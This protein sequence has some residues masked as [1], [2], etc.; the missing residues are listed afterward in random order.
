[1]KKT[2]KT[3]VSVKEENKLNILRGLVQYDTLNEVQ[4]RLSDGYN[5]F[6]YTG[7]DNIVLKVLKPDGTAYIDSLGDR[8]LATSPEDGVITLMLDGQATAAAGVC[9]SVIELYAAGE[10]MTTSRFNYEVFPNLPVGEAIESETEYP[11]LQQ[12]LM[13]L[14]ALQNAIDDAE[15][16]R[17][18]NEKARVEAEK[19][20]ESAEISRKAAETVRQDLE[21]GYVAKASQSAES[22]KQSEIIAKE[23]ERKAL[24]YLEQIVGMIWSGSI[25]EYNALP[26]I[27]DDVWYHILEGEI[28]V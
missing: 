26:V 20:R 17:V 6:D 28:P 7:C 14:S 8:I 9:Q 15:S 10:K 1:M 24:S 16:E 25:E 27:Y 18:S 3:T 21:S 5:A 2:F 19:E 12:L 4:I 22:A 11:I 13:D 23:S